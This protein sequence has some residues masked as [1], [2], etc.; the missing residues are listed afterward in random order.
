MIGFIKKNARWLVGVTS[1]VVIG[2]VWA[3]LHQDR[4]RVTIVETL[5]LGGLRF[6]LNIPN[7]DV[8]YTKEKTD[9][10]TQFIFFPE[11]RTPRSVSFRLADLS[12]SQQLDQTA[13]GTNGSVLDYRLETGMGGSGGS[14]F[15][16]F[17]VLR[18]EHI[19]IDVFCSVQGEFL[20]E[21]SA[22]WCVP[23]LQSVTVVN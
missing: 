12:V 18:T 13:R 6:T 4:T 10:G 14:M 2:L 23:T 19:S 1:L 21:K 15:F 11:A 8:A 16:L 17:G 5:E 20:S 22:R 9:I 3:S 7:Y